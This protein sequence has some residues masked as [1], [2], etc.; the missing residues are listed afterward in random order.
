[1]K[2]VDKIIAKIESKSQKSIESKK[3]L[4]KYIEESLTQKQLITFYNWECPPRTLEKGKDGK[5]Y[6]N[7]DVDL[8]S[9]FDGKAVDAYTEIP[10]VVCKYKKELRQLNFLKSLG[11]NFR[12]VK[13]IADTN[14]FYI[15]PDSFKLVN[16]TKTKEIFREFRSKIKN[17]LEKKYFAYNA[18]VFLF[19]EMMKE[20]KVVYE[21]SMDEFY[22]NKNRLISKTTWREQV[23]RTMKHVGLEKKKSIEFSKRVIATYA[24]EGIVFDTLSKED[25]FSNC[26]WLNIEEIDTRAIKITNCLRI[27]NGLEKLPMIFLK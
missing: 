22:K 23:M 24:A 19:T 21:R 18:E 1:M 26:V 11:L 15:T 14:A 16:K 2:I 25:Y 13:I 5:I 17:R 20:F 8:D 6:V 7:Y 10:R 3:L 27:R 4:K 12:F 9:I